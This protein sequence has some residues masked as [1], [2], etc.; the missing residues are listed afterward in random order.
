MHRMP[1]HQLRLFRVFTLDVLDFPEF[2]NGRIIDYMGKG[3][4]NRLFKV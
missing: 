1:V 2:E 4:E 3:K